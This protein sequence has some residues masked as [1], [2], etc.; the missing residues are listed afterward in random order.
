MFSEALAMLV[1]GVIGAFGSE[2]TERPLLRGD[3][4]YEANIPYQLPTLFQDV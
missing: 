2:C 4:H 3:I 1:W